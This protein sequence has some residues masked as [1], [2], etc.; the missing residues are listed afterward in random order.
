MKLKTFAF[1][2]ITMLSALA[3]TSCGGNGIPEDP[4]EGDVA[5]VEANGSTFELVYVAPGTFRMGATTEQDGFDSFTELPAHEV[6]LTKGYWIGKLEVSQTQ[7]EA[8]MGNNPSGIKEYDGKE[9]KSLPVH[10]ITW[11]E[12]K[13]FTKKLSEITGHKFRLPTEAEWEYA[14]RGASKTFN[15]QYSGSKYYEN[16]ACFQ[17][18]SNGTPHPVGQFMPNE[19]DIRDMNGNVSEWVE[20]NFTT[21]KDSAQVDPCFVIADTLSHAARGGNFVSTKTQLR[22]ASR[23]NYDADFKSASVGLRIIMEAK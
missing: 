6:Q 1:S 22:T 11:A 13:A 9:D 17:G 23:E 16:V 12:A 18:N 5:S 21:Y 10:S 4:K 20:D 7:W 2:G 14:A 15:H 8:V 3:I 19:L